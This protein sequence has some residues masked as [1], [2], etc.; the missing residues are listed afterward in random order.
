[1]G[2]ACFSE[3]TAG[4]LQGIQPKQGLT[5]TEHR[6]TGALCGAKMWQQRVAEMRKDKPLKNQEFCLHLPRC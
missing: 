6:K 2:Y 5:G 3:L 1:M 4:L